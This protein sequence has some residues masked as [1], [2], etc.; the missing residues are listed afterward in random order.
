MNSEIIWKIIDTY[1][2]DNPYALVSH[3][4]D[5]YN[6]F[7]KTGLR[8]IF[9]EKNPIQVL[10]QQDEETKEFNLDC[11]L[12]LGG[13]EG[14]KIY[15]GKPVI[16]DE[17]YEHFM[18]PNEARLRNMTYGFSVH[19]DVDVEFKINSD[20][21][22]E[23]TI[24]LEKVYLGR[25]PIMLQS[26]MC[27]LQ[28]LDPKVR[29][30]TGECIND[31]GGYF[32]I[33]GKEK[34]LICQEKF[35]DNM[36]YIRDNYSDMYE[37]SV[38]VKS[39]SEDAAKPKR[40][41]AVRMV[42]PLPTQSNGQ[43][44]VTIPNVRKPVP[45]FIVMRALGIVSDKAIIETCLLDM[46]KNDNYVDLFIPSIHDASI[47]FTQET[48]LKYIATFT[49]GKTVPHVLEI[50]SDYFLPH[51]GEMNFKDKAY[52]I[53]HM[54]F[55][56]LRT[57]QKEQ[58]PTDRDNFKYKRVEMCGSLLADLFKEYYAIMQHKIFQK[59]DK[60]YYYHESQYQ[61]EAFI[62]LIE[63]NYKEFFKE[64]DVEVGFRKAFKGNWGAEAH[65]KKPGVVQDLNRLSFNSALA[66]RRKINLP[67]DASAKVIG[68]R[69]LHSSQWGII[70]PLDTPDGGNV[71]LHKHMSIV[72]KI[73]N[74]Y[75][76]KP[77]IQ[78]LRSEGYLRF[79]TES[80]PKYMATNTKVFVNGAWLG[81]TPNPIG[82]TQRFR[83]LRRLAVIPVYTSC[84]WNKQTNEIEIY[85]DGG[86]L[87]RPIF[88][89]D[90]ESRQ[91]SLLNK[92][93]F[94]Y[95]EKGA[96][97]WE[98]L[99][100]GFADKKTEGFS[101][102]ANRVYTIASLYGE[103]P[104]SLSDKQAIIEYMDS[105][106]ANVAYIS[107]TMQPSFKDKDYT[108]MDIHPSLLLGVM[109]NQ[110]IFPE[111][112]QL[113]R[114]LFSCGQSKQGASWYHTNFQN[115]IDKMGVVLNYG[116]KPAVKSRYMHYINK[117][118]QP[119]G[120]NPVVAIMCYGGYNVE[121]SI[122]FNE[123]SVKRGM[124]RTTYLNSYEAREEA[125]GVGA[126][127]VDSTFTDIQNANV[128]GT[129]PGF[130]YGY[131]DE[132][133]LIR[134]NTE[135]NDKMTVIGK[136][137][138]DLDDPSLKIDASV[139]PKKGQL[140]FVDK[141]FMT[142]GEEGRRIAKVRIR[143]ERVPA[144]GDKFCSRCGQKGTIGRIIPERDMPFTANGIR[145]DIIVNPH[146]F[147]SRMTIGQLV[148]VIVAKAGV[149]YG[150]FGD[151]TAFL[152]QGPKQELFGKLLTDVGYNK[153]GNEVLYN[154]L[155]GE[156]LEADIFIGPTYYMR[157]K[158]MV[159]DK[160]NYRAQGPRT[161]LTRQTVQGR[162]N[163]GGLRV[164][165]MERD[166]V[167]AHGAAKFLEES[168]T[169]R[170]DE[171]FMAICNNSGTIAV[172]NESK[173]IFLSPMADGPIKFNGEVNDKLSVVN[174]SK[175]GRDF[176]VVRVP[177]SFKLLMQ[178]LL[179][180][181]IQMRVI[182]EDN[183][184]QLTSMS[185]SNNVTL[186]LK[187]DKITPKGIQEMNEKLR[188]TRVDGVVPQEQ[189]YG[190]P[191]SPDIPGYA[192]RSPDYAPRSP[193][194][195]PRSPDY[196]PR[197]P[198]YAPRSPD[199]APR[200][201]D[202]APRSPDYA[203]R[204]PDGP[205]TP[206]SPEFVPSS[207]D[208]FAIGDLV[209]LT[210][211]DIASWRTWKISNI[212]KENDEYTLITSET[213]DLPKSATLSE[214]GKMA[215]FLANKLDLKKV[216]PWKPYRPDGPY[217]PHSPDGPY[218]PHSPDGPYTPQSPPDPRHWW[219]QDPSTLSPLPAHM[220][221]SQ[222]PPWGRAPDSPDGPY[223]PHSPDVPMYVGDIE[224]LVGDTVKLSTDSQN[225]NRP[226]RIINI[227]QNSGNYTLTTSNLLGLP[228]SA[229]ISADGTSYAILIAS[230]LE[231]SF[232]NS[233][234]SPEESPPQRPVAK[235]GAVPPP[236][237]IT[238]TVPVPASLAPVPDEDP[239][240]QPYDLRSPSPI[241]KYLPPATIN[242]PMVKP[243]S[244]DTS[245][246]GKYLPDVAGE[247]ENIT[248]LTDIVES[249]ESADPSETDNSE[250][251]TIN[252]KLN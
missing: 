48:A 175:Y 157:L 68:P 15:Y 61:G 122:L 142:E 92:S 223:T 69:L 93:A 187:D 176:S 57:S 232:V 136:A 198:D 80:S 174:I 94:E 111:N 171:Y 71:G 193:D 89:I 101:V 128:I 109:G 60:E 65:T 7:F 120:E 16:Y 240:A 129:K 221:S 40:T 168:M 62:N 22:I 52:F 42:S 6:L 112:N 84:A 25:F 144:V 138:T 5:S 143:E 204:S 182:T 110:I 121:D 215:T 32:I 85:T 37:Y 231:I 201:P 217:T 78:L 105:S 237:H 218:T 233:P 137:T 31:P 241:E 50:L 90:E 206:H 91:L 202:Y 36:L 188:V 196:A 87:C 58:A 97:T 156:Q 235:Y 154:G 76:P 151:C 11:K 39:A 146:A 166:G 88:Y 132:Y 197:S 200:S 66:Q 178:E 225:P 45:L 159:K 54:A 67:L 247:K 126:G 163:D 150:A 184:D 24:T 227:D 70:D 239:F 9:K 43:I 205:Y 35:G 113:P 64:R 115:R 19:F 228:S 28:N 103:N 167:I 224:Y 98:G 248:I 245:P 102:D 108:H 18:Y 125:V 131:L 180:M 59:I 195:A 27:I 234:R 23:H 149:N 199:Y 194:Y 210:N 4:Q 236:S 99:I 226:W 170:G 34:V 165:E 14:D 243:D 164:G 148:E 41:T 214:N 251:K 77:L 219:K 55:T 117:E 79:L 73:T 185:Y 29:F 216:I 153:T 107:S 179:T 30:E 26:D 162:A 249:N 169:T 63:N 21:Q 208:E 173:N 17:N 3:H 244:A 56:L 118:T 191:R 192:P 250:K 134:E 140:G 83:F 207:P 189:R 246:I 38:E 160:I 44:V 181:N 238:R 213:Y 12:Y 96:I 124:F 1:F 106:E 252:I 186:L 130:D 183:V 211:H 230:K 13:K 145:P 242:K 147:P 161:L 229:K 82:M 53:G 10:K 75:S 74:G 127:A 177:Y 33:D 114:N 220:V 222:T 104:R 2:E 119:Y 212:N 209:N 158:H 139:Y 47:V 141:A 152:N 172:Y 8:Q 123:A 72:A 86:R 46:E 95:V 155:T 100:S 190:Q 20:T 135:L 133:G 49:K 116:Q 203:P 51:I 81:V